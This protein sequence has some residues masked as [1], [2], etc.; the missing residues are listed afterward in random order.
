M[1]VV[2]LAPT[3]P[4]A[5]GIAGWTDRMMKAT[6]KNGWEVEVVDEKQIG[7]R[8]LFSSNK[9]KRNFRDE[10]KRCKRIWNDLKRALLNDEVKVV[11]SCI[12][13]TTFAMMREYVC[14]Y[15][16]HKMNK[17]FIIHFRCTLPNTTKGKLGRIILKKLCDKSDFV[18]VLNKQSEDFARA[19]TK[20]DISIVPNFVEL[21]ESV[22]SY[23]VR[24]KINKVIYV[25]GVIETKGALEA[26]DIAD[27]FPEIVFEFVGDV[28]EEN[29]YLANMH[30]N[31]V[32]TGAL[33]HSEVKEKLLGADVFL[34]PTH[35][36][37][38]GFSNSLCEAMA[39]GLPCLVTDWAANADMIDD[40][41]GGYV[42]PI[43]D[44]DKAVKA[45]KD[46]NNELVR[47]QMSIYNIKKVHEEYSQVIVTSKYVDIYE[48]IIKE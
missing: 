32:L 8:E 25:G 2:L 3:P 29:R 15:I 4:P 16:T 5:G 20:T 35:F 14:A 23:D 30:N 33:P 27:Y 45:L 7:N 28:P 31:V 48:R 40:G 46:M 1:K 17:K 44:V 34:F 42:V 39:V 37:G 21:E 10:W 19:I 13:S 11:H 47:K 36:Y 6:L 22:C 43:H 24:D 26:F 12:P 38:E 41:K 18:M 9:I